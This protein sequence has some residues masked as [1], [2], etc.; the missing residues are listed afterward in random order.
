MSIF[1]SFSSAI[2]K[3]F[4]AVGTT[5]TSVDK[6]LDVINIYVDNNHK[7]LDRTIKQDA[8]LSAAKH[9]TTIR[10]QLDADS[11]LNDQFE[12]LLADW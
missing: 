8:I 12:S 3:T 4:D 2:T 9:H 5:A 1:S 10:K 6:T 11:T 7:R